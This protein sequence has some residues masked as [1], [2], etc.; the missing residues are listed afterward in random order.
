MHTAHYVLEKLIWHFLNQSDAVCT[1]CQNYFKKVKNSNFNDIKQA[2]VM[3][4]TQINAIIRPDKFF[5][6]PDISGQVK[7][8]SGRITQGTN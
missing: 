1:K 3:I 7:N 5:I 2:I 4:S 8:L 6:R